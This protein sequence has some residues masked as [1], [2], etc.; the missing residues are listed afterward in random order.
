KKIDDLELTYIVASHLAARGIAIKCVSHVIN[1]ELKSA[2]DFYVHS[3]GR[4]AR[5]CSSGIALSSY[6][7]ADADA[8]VQ[9][10]KL[11]DVF[12]NK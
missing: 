11:G 7:F 3:V 2:I 1:Y 8:F 12:V 4:T 6:D 5:V 9:V 10:E